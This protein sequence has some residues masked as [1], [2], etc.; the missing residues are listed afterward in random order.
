MKSSGIQRKEVDRVK[1]GDPVRR[2]HF[3]LASANCDTVTESILCSQYRLSS[4]L[5]LAILTPILRLFSFSVSRLPISPPR[6]HLGLHMH[7]FT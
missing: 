2:S 4:T 1:N 7:V 6:S 5:E 3:H